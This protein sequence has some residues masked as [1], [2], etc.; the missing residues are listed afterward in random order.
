MPSSARWVRT[1]FARGRSRFSG[2]RGWAG[3]SASGSTTPRG[4]TRSAPSAASPCSSSTPRRSW[5]CAAVRRAVAVPDHD[6]PGDARRDG[7]VL[8][9]NTFFGLPAGRSTSS[10]RARCRPW[11]STS[12]KLLLEARRSSSSAPTATAGRWRRWPRAVCWRDEGA[13]RSHH[14]LF[15]GRQPA[16]PNLADPVF[17]GH[18]LHA[19]AEVSSKVRRQGRPEGEDGRLRRRRWPVHASSSIPTCPTTGP[20]N[21]R[22]RAGCAVGGQPGDSP[23]R[24]G[25]PRPDD[26]RPGQAPVS[27]REEEGAVSSDQSGQRVEP[28]NENAL[29]FERFIFDVLPAARWTVVETTRDEFAPL[30]NATGADSPATVLAALIRQAADW[31]EHAGAVVPRCRRNADGRGRD[32]PPRCADSRRRSTNSPSGNANRRALLL[33]IREKLIWS[34]FGRHSSRRGSGAWRPG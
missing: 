20:R 23:L 8:R 26:A 21:R 18:H 4:C 32:Q 6:Q 29:K 24:R 10:A 22:G 19:R 14:L 2:R 17:L 3:H 28:A 11:T 34:T 25:V 30:K 33:G 13:R 1:H 12:G 31:L 27:H 7:R 5:P 15:P 16:H 9:Q